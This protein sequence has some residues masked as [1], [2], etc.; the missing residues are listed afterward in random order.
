M[1]QAE[2]QPI[3]TALSYVCQSLVGDSNDT[4]CP[5]NA[6]R[7]L[8]VGRDDPGDKLVM[9]VQRHAAKVSHTCGWPTTN[10]LQQGAKVHG[11]GHLAVWPSYRLLS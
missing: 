5:L 8:D 3:G 9:V 7:Q 4:L 2:Q 1:Q 11:V 6:A 10:S